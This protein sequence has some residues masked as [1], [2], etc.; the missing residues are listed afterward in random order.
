MQVEQNK[1]S[2]FAKKSQHS[3]KTGN[4]GINTT[5]YTKAD[6]NILAVHSQVKATQGKN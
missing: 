6:F 3:G 2:G 5:V 1:W 4:R